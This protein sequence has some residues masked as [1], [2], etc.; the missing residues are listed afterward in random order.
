[1]QQHRRGKAIHFTNDFMMT[2]V[3]GINDQEI[4]IQR[5]AQRDVAGGKLLRHPVILAA[6]LTQDIF[7]LK[8]SQ[9]ILRTFIAAKELLD[10]YKN[11]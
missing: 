3:G 4:F 5:G 2:G 8:V 6:H 1:M 11:I 7:F 9:H 10:L